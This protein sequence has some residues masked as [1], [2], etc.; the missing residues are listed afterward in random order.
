VNTQ[1]V[2]EIASEGEGKKMLAK[3]ED[4]ISFL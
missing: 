2:E 4:F 3:Q 1:V